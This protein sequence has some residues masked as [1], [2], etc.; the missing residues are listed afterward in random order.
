MEEDVFRKTKASVWDDIVQVRRNKAA[1]I[2]VPSKY[3][4]G[5]LHGVSKSF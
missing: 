2:K 1:G 3:K 5:L 4:T